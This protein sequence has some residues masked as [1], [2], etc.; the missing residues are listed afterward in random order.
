MSILPR[1][2]EPL[3]RDIRIDIGAVLPHDRAEVQI[4][5]D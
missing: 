5:A 1:G 3:V 4:D 2:E